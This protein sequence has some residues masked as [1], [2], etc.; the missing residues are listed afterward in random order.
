M[1]NHDGAMF[2]PRLLGQVSEAEQRAREMVMLIGIVLQDLGLDPANPQVSASV[3]AS[4]ERA[5][6]MGVIR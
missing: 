5:Q 6:R 4:F 2:D 1:A 3:E